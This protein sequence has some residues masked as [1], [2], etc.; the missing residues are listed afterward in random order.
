MVHG[1]CPVSPRFSCG[2]SIC[3]YLFSGTR[4]HGNRLQN[5]SKIAKDSGFF[6]A[7]LIY[8]RVPVPG[9]FHGQRSLAGSSPRDRKE[10]D[11]T[12]WL[13]LV[14]STSLVFNKVIIHV[15]LGEFWKIW[16]FQRLYGTKGKISATVWLPLPTP[17]AILTEPREDS[18]LGFVPLTFHCISL[19][20]SLK[21][22]NGER[23]RRFVL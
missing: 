18:E 20:D 13:T 6:L 22:R 19:R 10:L 9:E 4:A 23:N 1:H 14:T 8:W 11:T 15:G 7:T 2:T 3:C 5:A 16:G 21:V 12:E 17:R